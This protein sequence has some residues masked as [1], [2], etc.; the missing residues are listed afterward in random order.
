MVQIPNFLSTSACIKN[1]PV[2][3]E[4]H[5]I[6]LTHLRHSY[7]YGDQKGTRLKDK[8]LKMSKWD[9]IKN[10]DRNCPKYGRGFLSPSIG[11]N[12]RTTHDNPGF[13]LAIQSLCHVDAITALR[14]EQS[15]KTHQDMAHWPLIYPGPWTQFWPI[16]VFWALLKNYKELSHIKCTNRLPLTYRMCVPSEF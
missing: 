5:S 16:S 13:R 8:F 15:P 10:H 1:S 4:L 14:H 2:L 6:H 12:S 7:M 11:H 3:F 9:T